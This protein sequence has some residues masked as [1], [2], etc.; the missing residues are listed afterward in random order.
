LQGVGE[1][2]LFLSQSHGFRYGFATVGI[3]KKKKKNKEM[4]VANCKHCA[5][6][7]HN[8]R[9]RFSLSVFCK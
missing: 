4:R 9:K 3:F 5:V 1:Y 8:E 2:W 7:T 6:F